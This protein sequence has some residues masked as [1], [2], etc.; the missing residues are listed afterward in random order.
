M[1]RSYDPNLLTSDE[2]RSY[3]IPLK[4]VRKLCNSSVSPALCAIKIFHLMLLELLMAQ[5]ELVNAAI[6]PAMNVKP[7]DPLG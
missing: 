3:F 5:S 6:S 7:R 2:I 1:Q 4:I